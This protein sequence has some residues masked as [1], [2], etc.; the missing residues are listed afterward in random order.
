MIS[1]ELIRTVMDTIEIVLTSA[2]ENIVTDKCKDGEGVAYWVVRDNRAEPGKKVLCRIDIPQEDYGFAE[3][4][5]K[6]SVA[7]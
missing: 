7:N 5:G 4:D 6:R 2:T 3:A 1:E